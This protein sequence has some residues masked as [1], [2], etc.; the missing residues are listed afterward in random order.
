MKSVRDSQKDDQLAAIGIGAMIVFIALILVAAVAAAVII[1]T[2]EMLQQNAQTTGD[3]TA[4][5]MAGKV[6]IHSAFVDPGDTGNYLLL[7]SL[8]PGSED[9]TRD[10]LSFQLFC[11]NGV[12]EGDTDA[13]TGTPAQ[14]ELSFTEMD[15]TALAAADPLEPGQAYQM[16]LM[17]DIGDDCSAT[18]VLADDGE[19]NLYIHV[20]NGGSTF[21]TFVV[22][23]AAAGAIVV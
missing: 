19:A 9:T 17:A 20:A 11:D 3:D 2:A 22:D 12:I 5:N 1:Q 15:G 10:Q 23:S 21:E 14:A 6:L 18:E 4:D 7:I 13:A 16:T 8:A